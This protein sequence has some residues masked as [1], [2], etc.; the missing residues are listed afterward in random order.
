MKLNI[1]IEIIIGYM[2]GYDAGY[3]DGYSKKDCDNCF[4]YNLWRGK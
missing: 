1:H 4:Y 2:F 3:W